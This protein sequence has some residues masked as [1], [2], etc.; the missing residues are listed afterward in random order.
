MDSCA[1]AKMEE[2]RICGKTLYVPSTEICGRRVI[3]TG[4]RIRMAE[5]K[6]EGVVEGMT[7]ADPASF[8]TTLKESGLRADV[9]TFAQR[10]PETTPKYDY[11][12]EWD[13]WA[14]IPTTCFEDWW[15]NLPQVSRKNVRR[16]GRRGVVVKVIP[17]DDDLVKGVHRIYNSIQVRDGRLFWHYGQDLDSVKRSLGTYLDR[18]EFIGA[19]LGEELIGFLKMV[20][21]DDTA[22]IFHIISMDEHYDKRPQNALIA[23]AAEV[24]GQKAISHLIYGKFIYGNKRRS[25]LVEFKRRNGFQQV[26]FP[27]YYIPL[28]PRGELFVRLRLYRGVSGLLPEPILYLA[29]SCRDWY[30]KRISTN[31]PLQRNKFAGV[32]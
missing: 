26:N 15:E 31:L 8:I 22:T 21:V 10:P 23:K 14:A 20:Y 25:S 4:K 27:R 3:V 17:F 16:A 5:I 32:A 24:C 9:F 6:D 13:N 29:L 7:V 1:N 18:S 11:H 2:I 30:H 19:Y 28:T 12:R